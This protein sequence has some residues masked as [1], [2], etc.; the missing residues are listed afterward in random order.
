MINLSNL[1]KLKK[2]AKLRP[3]R[4]SRQL[5]L[6]YYKALKQLTKALKGE[7]KR[8]LITALK[9]TKEEYQADAL[10][11]ILS[12]I[13]TRLK[14]KAA[15]LTTNAEEASVSVINKIAKQNRQRFLNA[16]NQATGVDLSNILSEEGVNDFVKLQSQK[17][18]SL[19]KSIPDEFFK[20]I[21]TIV[22]N[23]VAEGKRFE[24]IAKEITATRGI[25]SVFGKLENRAKLIAR[26]EVTTINAAIT[27]KRSELLG[28]KKGVWITAND[29]RVRPC[30][31]ARDGKEFD[32]AKGLYS[33]C[34]GKT[35]FPA[36]EINCR[37][38]Y[39]P[40]IGIEE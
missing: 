27:R 28:I 32:L 13:F 4:T 12:S 5:E 6:E 31:K 20:N 23:G 19:I 33:A 36:E 16:A 39:A 37:C 9:E 18:I 34:D 35:I 21:E 3:V 2:P 24:Q 14:N 26:N 30:H 40:V 38:D 29:E 17:N 11:D 8:E 22:Y 15:A 1:A 7:V 25:S 10:S